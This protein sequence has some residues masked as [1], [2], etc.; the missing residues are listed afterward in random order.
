MT[1]SICPARHA[2]N[3]EGMTRHGQGEVLKGA[4]GPDATLEQG[5]IRVGHGRHPA[6]AIV[7]PMGRVPARA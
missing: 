2:G 4:K 5:G 6:R 7:R 3:A 1:N